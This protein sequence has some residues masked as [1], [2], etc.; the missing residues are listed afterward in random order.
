MFPQVFVVV[1][2]FPIEVDEAAEGGHAIVDRQV[3]R[4]RAGL[5]GR[6]P[7]DKGIPSD[8][9]VAGGPADDAVL[10]VAVFGIVGAVGLKEGVNGFDLQPGFPVGGVGFHHGAVAE[11]YVNVEVV[12]FPDEVMGEG[13]FWRGL[14]FG[15]E[16]E[17][18]EEDGESGDSHGR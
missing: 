4:H 5:R 18:E 12:P 10:Q 1:F 14:R 7:H 11:F 2:S 13:A 9:P 16:G 6:L 8:G 3:E 15:G 17:D